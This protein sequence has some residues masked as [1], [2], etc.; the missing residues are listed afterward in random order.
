ML[1]FDALCRRNTGGP[2]GQ[3]LFLLIAL[4]IAARAYAGEPAGLLSCLRGSCFDSQDGCDPDEKKEEPK[5]HYGPSE[6][7]PRKTLMQWS[8]GTS[9]SGG[10]PSMDEPLES[11]RPDFTES[12]QTVGKGVVQVEMGYTFTTDG[13]GSQR[14]NEQSFPEMLWRVGILAEWLEFRIAYNY[15]ANDFALD[16]VPI[17]GTSV[18]GS[19][20]L[21]LAFKICLTPQEGILPEMGIIPQM[22]VPSG[23]PG[24]TAGE[25]MPGV[26]W[27]YDWEFCKFFSIGGGTQV[28]RTRD[29]DKNIYTQFAQSITVGYQLTK[30]LRGFTEW[31][32]F[33]PNGFTIDRTQHYADGGFTYH[34][35]NNFQLDIRAGVGL[36]EAADD[37][38]CGS[39]V[40]VRF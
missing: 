12:P 36:N 37:F 31:Y 19:E 38:F 15:G 17:Q 11:D 24:L 8:Y 2:R 34:V 30:K 21:Y 27:V 18:K 6:C 9:F 13:S 22:T 25:V 28:N 7:Q 23:S 10:P 5:L 32:V 20:D 29:D 40:V 3:V 35:T 1:P 33:V 26:N 4:L 16:G 14:T 39:G